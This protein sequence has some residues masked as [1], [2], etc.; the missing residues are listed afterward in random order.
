MRGFKLKKRRVS[1]IPLAGMRHPAGVGYLIIPEDIEREDY[2]NNAFS[3]QTVSFITFSSERFDNIKV[4]KSI[5][6]DLD[7]PA[8]SEDL[9]SLIF[10]V[11]HPKQGVP[12]IIAVINKTDEVANLLENQF[13]LSKNTEE[14]HVEISGDAKKGFINILIESFEENGGEL[15]INITNKS[16][17]GK[18]NVIA[19]GDFN[20][21]I[22][23]NVSLT[24]GEKLSFKIANILEDEE[25]I[26]EII[27][28]RGVGFS[29]KDEF[30]NEILA[31]SKGVEIKVAEDGIINHGEGKEP[32][33]LGST[34][35][36]RLDE[37]VDAIGKLTV[38]T[39]LGPSGTPI[40]IVEFQAA[41][42]QFKAFLS[43]LSNTD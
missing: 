32:L 7:F 22:G 13:L 33:V 27:Y 24:V 4:N 6:E 17:T 42:K 5:F 40:N 18:V 16:K 25:A 35:Q 38:P 30:E 2:I 9:G 20:F 43:Q 8:K 11:S 10:W 31:T 1:K 28:E 37:I 36:K 26:T 14:G 29:Y 12:V 23:K 3:S 19:D 15:N 21:D 41:Q 39:G 34:L